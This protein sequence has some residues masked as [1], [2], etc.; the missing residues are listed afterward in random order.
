[1]LQSAIQMLDVNNACGFLCNSQS[2]IYKGDM[3]EILLKVYFGL[4][5]AFYSE[6]NACLLEVP[7]IEFNRTYRTDRYMP[8]RFQP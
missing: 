6:I 2:W 1:M 7:P 4:L 3:Q 8:I 5:G